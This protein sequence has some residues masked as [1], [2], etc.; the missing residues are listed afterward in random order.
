MGHCFPDHTSTVILTQRVPCRD[1]I[2]PE[3]TTPCDKTNCYAA[4]GNEEYQPG[5]TTRGNEIGDE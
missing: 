5:S 3:S 2:S 1:D 4:A